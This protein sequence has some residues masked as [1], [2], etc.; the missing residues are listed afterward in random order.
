MDDGTETGFYGEF[1]EINPP[2]SITWTFAWDGMPGHA[3][4][5]TVTFTEQDGGTLVSTVSVFDEPRGPRR[6]A[7]VRR[8]RTA[9][10]RPTTGSSELL[11][12]GRGRLTGNARRGRRPGARF[13]ESPPMIDREQ[14][15]HVARLARLELSDDEVETMAT[16]LSGILEHVDR[17]SALDLDGRRADLARCRA[18]ERAARRRADPQPAPRAGARA[19]A[20]SRRGRVPRP[21]PGRFVS[22]PSCSS[23]PPRRR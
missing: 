13:L 14:V 4:V 9:C 22:A 8:W 21:V 15:L 6:H 1:R 2:E 23:S 11:D 16:E 7:R 19:G 3:S 5:E 20:R 18:R 10:A 12:Q 17:I